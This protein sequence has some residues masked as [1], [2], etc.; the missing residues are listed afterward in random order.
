[1]G[2]ILGVLLGV[3]AVSFGDTVN[4][5]NGRSIDAKDTATESN[6]DSD[7]DPRTRK[8]PEGK[9]RLLF[10]NGG[11]QDIPSDEIESIE[12]NDKDAFD[13]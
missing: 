4:L 11:W 1:M 13:R 7:S 2:V 9:T 10:S 12:E 5:T 6:P 8:I 3:A